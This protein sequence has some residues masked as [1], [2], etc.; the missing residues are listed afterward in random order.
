MAEKVTKAKAT[1]E[2]FSRSAGPV[3]MHMEFANGEKKDFSARSMVAA[4]TEG[5]RLC[6]EQKQR[7][8]MDVVVWENS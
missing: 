5:K 4:V 8:P 1:T 3:K 2:A 6:Q 7:W